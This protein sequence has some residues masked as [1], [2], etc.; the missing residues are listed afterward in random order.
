MRR[1][2]LL[3]VLLGALLA[4]FVAGNASAQIVQLTISPQTIAFPSADP[5]TTPVLTAPPLT[6][7]YRVYV[8][9]GSE[10]RIT[11]LASDDF[12]NGSSVIPAS[13]VTWTASPTPPFRAGTLSSSLAQTLASGTGDVFYHAD[14]T[15]SF[16]MPNAWSYDVGTY[17]TT[18]TFTISCP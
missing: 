6:V 4:P 17:T 10:W 7:T 13:A 2:V 1:V 8:S 15:I 9:F 16:S 12:R 18:I 3:A 14:S 5:D 11:A